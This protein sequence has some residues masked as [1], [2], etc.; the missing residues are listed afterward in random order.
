MS[1][2]KGTCPVCDATIDFDNNVEESEIL[3]CTGCQTR[4][5]VEK[6][7][8]DS[9]KLNEAPQVEEDWGE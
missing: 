9:V 1:N 4:V 3:T 8:K 2:L 5:V 7:E 6:V